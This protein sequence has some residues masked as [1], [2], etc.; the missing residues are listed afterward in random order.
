M[1]ATHAIEVPV[2]PGVEPTEEER[3]LLEA[4]SRAVFALRYEGS[5]PEWSRT[6]S[7]LR[8]A[9]WD[10]HWRLNWVAEGRR[11]GHIEQGEGDSLDAALGEL[12]QLT[13][14]DEVEGCP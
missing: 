4:L 12:Q 2:P 6:A 11:G 10:V 1:I 5:E 13:L 14:L 8:R 7:T 3:S 9:G